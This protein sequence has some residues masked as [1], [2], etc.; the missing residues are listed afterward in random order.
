M[1]LFVNISFKDS[2]GNVVVE[3]LTKA[4][5]L[6]RRAEQNNNLQVN[7]LHDVLL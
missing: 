7:F 6:I 1:I 2:V 3:S 5:V 4:F